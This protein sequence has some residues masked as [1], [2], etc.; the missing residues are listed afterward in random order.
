MQDVTAAV[1]RLE[2]SYESMQIAKKRVADEV[3]ADFRATIRDEIERR[4]RSLEIEFARELAEEHANGLPG[5]VIRSKVLR[6]QDW[7]RWKKWRELAEIEP[8]RVTLRN[9]KAER[10]AANSPFVWADDFSTLTVRKNS[11]GEQIEPV[12]FY[13]HTN[14]MIQGRWFPD[15]NPENSTGL[16]QAD[17]DAKESDPKNWRRFVHEEIQR[18]VDAGNIEGEDNA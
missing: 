7:G 17:R 8:E 2:R 9:L 13:M 12:V 18:Q 10:E 5:N 16:S 4:Q 3:R 15:S 14:R 6:T 1:I 11:L